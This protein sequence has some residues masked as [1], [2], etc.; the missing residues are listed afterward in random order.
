MTSVFLCGFTPLYIISALLTNKVDKGLV[1]KERV[2]RREFTAYT[3]K[4]WRRESRIV[5]SPI[6]T[7]SLI[8]RKVREAYLIERDK[9]FEPLGIRNMKCNT[10]FISSICYH[11]F[12]LFYISYF[13]IS[14]FFPITTSTVFVFNVHFF[15][16]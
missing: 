4:I 13:Y 10:V 11:L 15:L 5:Y 7:R 6:F 1:F 8:W 3:I 2:E 12:I 14:N 16:I 9:T